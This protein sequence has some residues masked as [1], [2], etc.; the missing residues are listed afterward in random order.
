MN[1]KL[2][3]NNRLGEEK[4]N[5]QGCLMKI[6]EYINCH[7]IFVEFQDV[8]RAKVHTDYRWFQLGNVKNPYH[9][10]VYE[11]GIIGNKYTSKTNGNRIREYTA[12]IN[13]LRRCFNE[14]YKNKHSTYKDAICC[15]EWLNY[16]NFYEWLHN[17]ENFDKWRDNDRWAIDKDILKK[18]NKLYSPDTCCLVP[19]NVN[20]LFIKGNAM[21]GNL[22]I[23]VSIYKDK[24]RAVCNNNLA[25]DSEYLGDYLT[26]DKAFQAYKNY[27]ENS[28]KEIANIEY[29]KGNITKQCYDAMMNYRVEITD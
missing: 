1:K 10:S 29:S 11:V 28:I 12:W 17:Q 4:L 5:S 8:Y 3:T 24:F 9:P 19:Q 25:K 18:G 22:P 16:E 15:N 7:N 6:V 14:Q 23:G 13:M 2:Q 21:R 26:V 27:K 20:Q